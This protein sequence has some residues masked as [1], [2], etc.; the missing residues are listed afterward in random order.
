[1]QKELNRLLALRSEIEESLNKM[2]NGEERMLLS[3]RYV[4]HMTW[5]EIG[6]RLHVSGR[7]A[8]RIHATALK[9]FEKNVVLLCP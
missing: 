6:E 9:N 1:M 8:R 4:E 2:E 5:D 3:L 7:T